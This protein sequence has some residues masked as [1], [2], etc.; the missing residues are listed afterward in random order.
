MKET[1]ITVYFSFCLPPFQVKRERSDACITD[2]EECVQ[3]KQL[4]KYLEPC[5]NVVLSPFFLS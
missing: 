2:G 1:E 4:Q 3:K 5:E